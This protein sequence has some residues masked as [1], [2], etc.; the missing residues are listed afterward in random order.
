[1]S[2][3]RI[4]KTVI[5]NYGTA[6]RG[7]SATIKAL[8]EEIKKKYPHLK[9]LRPTKGGGDVSAIFEIDNVIF[10]LE[11]QG[12]P[13]SRIFESLDEFIQFDCD[14]IIVACR[15]WGATTNA[16][17]D[18]QK[19]GYRIIWAQNMHGDTP[20]QSQL[21]AHYVSNMLNVIDEIKIGTL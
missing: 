9:K 15:T 17:N 10:G 2:K 21:N 4:I 20:I 16:V 14:I 8:Y 11:S 7:K 5:A 3:H 1:M 6:N 18:L 12:D 19:E 13:N